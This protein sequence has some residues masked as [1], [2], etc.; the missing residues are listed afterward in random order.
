MFLISHEVKMKENELNNFIICK[1]CHTLH[2]KIELHHGTKALC[3]RCNG[4]L[5]RYH[6]KNFIDTLL[7]LSWVSF[8]FF[9]IA[10]IF[11]IIR[12]NIN[13]IYQN[14]DIS[15]IFLV[16]FNKEYY[17]VG[18]MLSL[19]IF[20]F[21]LIILISMIVLLTLIK[22]KKSKYLV[23]RLLILIAKLLPWSMVDIFFISILVAMVKLFDYAQLEL[24]I[25]FNAFLLVILLDIFILK[26]V[27]MSDIWEE[28]EKIYR[29]K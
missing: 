16:I 29:E 15:S 11:S 21:P 14:L 18:I 8:I 9:I 7:A 10:V 5:Y 13:G 2:R 4:V 22:L 19:L 27:N 28:Y 3:R 6:K 20:I 17:L 24:G 25:A 1:R 26:R 23:K 12:I